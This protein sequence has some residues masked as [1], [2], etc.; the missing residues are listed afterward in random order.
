LRC[1]L[2]STSPRRK[3][4]FSYICKEFDVIA[5]SYTEKPYEGSKIESYVLSQA[6]GK[7]DSVSVNA[8]IVVAS[9][10]VVYLPSSD[11]VLGKPRDKDDAFHMLKLLMGRTHHVITG[12]AIKARG[13]VKLIHE[14][15]QV[16]FRIV[17]NSFIMEYVSTGSPLD[18]AGAYGIQDPY[19]AILV[20]SIVGDYYNVV[21]FPVGRV[22]EVLSPYITASFK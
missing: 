19:G 12:V 20:E 6:K 1:I 14:I 9:D 7:L 13:D 8:D 16:K 17:P 10:T 5:P 4:L 3:E 15:T 21:G 2:A 22:W 18:K 11:M